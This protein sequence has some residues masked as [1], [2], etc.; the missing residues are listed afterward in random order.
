MHQTSIGYRQTD[1]AVNLSSRLWLTPPLLAALLLLFVTGAARAQQVDWAKT[2]SS[3]LNPGASAEGYGIAV[4]DNG[5]SVV[6][7][8]FQGTVL[9]GRNE[10]NVT[11]LT[12]MGNADIFIAR[13]AADGTLRWVKG[14]GA[15]GGDGG[16]QVA[17]DGYGNSYVVGHFVGRATFGTGANARTL[18]SSGSGDLFL[19]KL[20]PAGNF[21][22]VQQAGGSVDATPGIAVTADGSSYVTGSFAGTATIALGAAHAITLNS[23]GDRDLFVA[24]FDADGGLL[25]VNQAG[26]AAF[27]SGRGIAVDRQGYSYVTGMFADT[28]TFDSTTT[29]AMT[30]T[31]SGG[32]DLFIARYTA[33]GELVWVRKAG[34]S[35]NDYGQG[36][37]VD[38]AGTSTVT[39]AQGTQLYVARYTVD[40]NQLWAAAAGGGSSSAW[41]RA[42]A[43]DATGNSHVVGGFSGG[44]SFSFVQGNS[45]FVQFGLPNAG[46][47]DGFLATYNADGSRMWGRGIGG[48]LF[49]DAY[50]VAVDG[51]GN[52]YVTGYFMQTAQIYPLQ[53]TATGGTHLFTARFLP[54]TQPIIVTSTADPGDGVCA[55]TECTL[56]EAL[57]LANR[58]SGEDT[59]V[60]NLPE[61]GTQT[62]QPIGNL[63]DIT[64]RVIIDGYTQPGAQPN[65]NPMGEA[66][67]AIIKVEIDGSRATSGFTFTGNSW[68]STVRGLAI[69]RFRNQAIYESRR[70]VITGNFIGTDPTGSQA[71]GNGSGIYSGGGVGGTTPRI[72]GPAPADRNL[73]VGNQTGVWIG[74]LSYATVEGNFIGTDASGSNALGNQIGVIASSCPGCE[75]GRISLYNNLIAGN[76][77]GVRNNYL[78]SS[79]GGNLVG[80]DRTGQHPLPNTGD[81]LVLIGYELSVGNNV[82]AYNGNNGIQV[83]EIIGINTITIANNRIFANGAAG[84]SVTGNR[85]FAQIRENR[86]Y[87][88]GGL[89]IDLGADGV[90]PNDLG[91][92]DLGPNRR[93]NY[94][95]LRL[96]GSDQNSSV[97]HGVINSTPNRTLTLHF[98]ANQR[99][100]ATGYGE[101]E[102][103]L[104]NQVVTTDSSGNAAFTVNL[105]QVIP[106]GQALTAT[107]TDLVNLTGWEERATSEFARC[108]LVAG[109]IN[110]YLR[111]VATATEYNP[112]PAPDAP[113]GVFTIR[114]TFVNQSDA[115]LSGLFFKVQRLTNNNR[116][117]NAE[118]VVG[119]VGAVVAAPN[120][121]PAGAPVTVTFRIGLQE[122]APFTFLVDSYGMPTTAVTTALDPAQV[123]FTYTPVADELTSSTG[124]EAVIYLPLVSSE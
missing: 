91:D 114:A 104:A 106:V 57:T 75:M 30:L 123:G 24:R 38:G 41:G 4:A 66:I 117:L 109:V 12:S 10:P 80:T 103:V 19:A 68:N 59:I 113:A 61:L 110:S 102:F 11:S 97:F 67:N 21:L 100:D 87:D 99:C 47:S 7:G 85:A 121:L 69:N 26:G 35:S 77:I 49:D 45:F 107:A 16:W 108:Q 6:T 60:F 101:G 81:G 124:E 18:T 25:W 89:G 5:E 43:V 33:A 2:S 58:L 98:Y 20:D 63:P 17:L 120:P 53:L 111:A 90:T 93:Q 94:P 54:T 119:G 37:A 74:A 105:P 39:G 40:G 64:D 88:N 27:D 73:I 22:W 15:A 36:I 50:G 52:S 65:T 118:G 46:S 13:Y 3:Y 76:G 72:G 96:A 83:M 8:T 92:G 115:E 9:F 29:Q 62:I 86:I 71:L 48:A 32:N 112:T 42:V 56:R 78:P 1:R 31:S 70:L 23:R 28:A 14:V 95:E 122:R 116:L 44:V 34:G 79:I 55:A 51:A 82:I 84:I